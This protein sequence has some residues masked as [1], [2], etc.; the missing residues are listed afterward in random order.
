[1]GS[2]LRPLAG[3]LGPD[4]LPQQACHCGV[5]RPSHI[6]SLP[7]G[8]R[9][10]RPRAWQPHPGFPHRRA[11]VGT[12]VPA[13]HPA[14]EGLSRGSSESYPELD[15]HCGVYC[16]PGTLSLGHCRWDLKA[17]GKAPDSSGRLPARS[18]D[19]KERDSDE[20]LEPMKATLPVTQT[21]RQVGLGGGGEGGPKSSGPACL[22]FLALG[23][24]RPTPGDGA[25]SFG[26]GTP[27]L[28]GAASDAGLPRSLPPASHSPLPC[29]HCPEA[30]GGHWVGWDMAD[31]SRDREK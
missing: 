26:P 19:R 20:G 10:A 17:R 22:S 21:G 15:S 30:P 28:Q 13:Q 18:W 27:P 11:G 3:T 23:A 2:E 14:C 12:R 31:L 24:A 9:A 8:P 4:L 7:W 16:P 29:C 25:A 6:P 1:M 5:K